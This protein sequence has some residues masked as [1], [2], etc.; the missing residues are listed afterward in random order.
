MIV[1]MYII[2]TNIIIYFIILYYIYGPTSG[3]P[4]SPRD[5]VGPSMYM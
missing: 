2:V 3:G 4:P 1:W 5:A